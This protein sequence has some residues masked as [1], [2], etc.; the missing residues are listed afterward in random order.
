VPSITQ[1]DKIGLSWEAPVF[2][3][4]SQVIDYRILYDSATGSSFTVYENQ[5]SG[6]SFTVTGLT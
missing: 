5:A 1:A 6:S 4:G 3:G 2:N